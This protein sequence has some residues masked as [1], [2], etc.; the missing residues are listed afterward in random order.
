M[1]RID[2]DRE[3]CLALVGRLMST[4]RKARIFLGE[5]DSFAAAIKS[6]PGS[7]VRRARS[8]DG[9]QVEIAEWGILDAVVVAHGKVSS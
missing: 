5:D 3:L 9:G 6:I 1:S 2:S 8:D 7:K 4:G